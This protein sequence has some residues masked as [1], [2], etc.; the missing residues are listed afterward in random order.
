MNRYIDLATT[1]LAL[2]IAVEPL[3]VKPCN[4][5]RL[6]DRGNLTLGMF[7]FTALRA[8]RLFDNCLKD[9]KM[10]IFRFGK[11]IHDLVLDVFTLIG[12]NTCIGTSILLVPIAYATYSM[13]YRGTPPSDIVSV[14]TYA[15]FLVRKYST[16]VDTL[17]FYKVLR[18]IAPS[19]TRRSIGE[20]RCPDI[21]S[22]DYDIKIIRGNISLWEVFEESSQIDIVCAQVVDCYCD[23]IKL[24]NDIVRMLEDNKFIGKTLLVKLLLR[25]V[26]TMLLRKYG[27]EI[28]FE[29]CRILLELI[30]GAYDILDLAFVNN[31]YCRNVN[32][33]SFADLIACALSLVVLDSLLKNDYDTFR[34]LISAR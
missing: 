12:E 8:V 21:Y 2:G 6:W 33:G 29:L 31:A 7:V 28:A 26:D 9:V 5:S 11:R 18:T 15:T 20:A 27:R 24:C 4:V 16:Y 3:L 34:K 23:V 25:Y 19:Y 10:G 30:Q 14:C 1:A 13:L 32:L 22:H 17:Y